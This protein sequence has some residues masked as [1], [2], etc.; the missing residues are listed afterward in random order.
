MIASFL[1]RWA[2][3]CSIS[4]T[5]RNTWCVFWTAVMK[6][7]MTTARLTRLDV[8]SPAISIRTTP[9]TSLRDCHQFQYV[10]VR[11]VKIEAAAAAPIVELAVFKAPGR[12][13]EHNLG[14]F[15]PAKNGV[16]LAIADIESE[17]MVLKIGF[18]IEQ[19]GQFL[20]H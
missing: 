4:P 13:A 1:T 8:F 19:Q 20:V 5:S 7:S 2:N 12:A 11:I 16:E 18:I 15:D 10:P 9:Q 3:D 6:I 14:F 17:M